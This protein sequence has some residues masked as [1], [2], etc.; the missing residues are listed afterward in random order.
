M[1]KLA[2]K[3]GTP[4]WLST[5]RTF[6]N[7]VI[8]LKNNFPSHLEILNRFKIEKS[9]NN[10]GNPSCK[11]IPTNLDLCIRDG[12]Y[13]VLISERWST[14]NRDRVRVRAPW[15][16]TNQWQLHHFD[17][18]NHH[19]GTKWNEWCIWR[20]W[21]EVRRLMIWRMKYSR[22]CMVFTALRKSTYLFNSKDRHC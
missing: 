20:G 11:K 12:P 1:D 7:S 15:E 18:W 9:I 3:T 8:S 6:R 5:A 19:S 10:L 21:V 4:Q 22:W 13:L 2:D 14:D 16:S 17:P